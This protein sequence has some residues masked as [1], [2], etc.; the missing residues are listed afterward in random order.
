A[1]E[2]ALRGSGLNWAVLRFPFVYGDGDGHLQGLP[3]LA[4]AHGLHPATR[5]SMIHHRDVA[6]AIRLALEGRCDR[7]VVN[8]CGEAPTT[9]Y[10]LAALVGEPVAGT[11]EPLDQPWRLHVDGSLAR[12]LGFRP[13]VRTVHQAVQDGL[14]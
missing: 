11:S 12:S 3:A 13:G 2:H 6:V 1:A 4:E 9:L 10:E 8:I 14:M 7:R 5:L